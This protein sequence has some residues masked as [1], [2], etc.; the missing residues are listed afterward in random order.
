MLLRRL[1]TAIELLRATYAWEL[2]IGGHPEGLAVS[3][4]G[5][6]LYVSDQWSGTVAVAAV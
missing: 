4:D 1:T 3:P 5:G 2:S 6:H